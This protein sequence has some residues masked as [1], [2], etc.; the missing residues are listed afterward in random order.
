MSKLKNH[1]LILLIIF[2]LAAPQYLKILQIVVQFLMKDIFGINMPKK[3][4]KNGE[5]QFIF[6]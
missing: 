6:S 4:N 1:F 5:P 3:L 2:I